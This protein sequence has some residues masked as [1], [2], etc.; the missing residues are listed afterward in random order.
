MRQGGCF[1]EAKICAATASRPLIPRHSSLS[2]WG[3]V[4]E[5]A[6]ETPL[7]AD[8][9]HGGGGKGRRLPCSGCE[10]RS[11]GASPAVALVHAWPPDPTRAAAGATQRIG[12]SANSVT[13]VLHS[14]AL[15]G[16][17]A[18]VLAEEVALSN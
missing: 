1:I 17:R 12:I 7:H 4:S 6:G 11:T 8:K 15:R 18:P 14:V 3:D 10:Q 16:R 13:E 5:D 2:P 9:P